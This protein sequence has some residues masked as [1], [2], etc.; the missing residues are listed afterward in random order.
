MTTATKS[1]ALT[2]ANSRLEN[3]TANTTESN[4]PATRKA[5]TNSDNRHGREPGYDGLEIIDPLYSTSRAKLRRSN[6]RKMGYENDPAITGG[7]SHYNTSP[8]TK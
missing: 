5:N 4:H 7:G 6:S 2:T 8:G 3:G 1:T